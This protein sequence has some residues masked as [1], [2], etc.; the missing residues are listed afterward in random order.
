M[1]PI[2]DRP[3]IL[4]ILT[5]QQ[6]FDS[7][8]CYGNDWIETPNLDALASQSFVFENAYVTQPVC[9]PAR[10]SIMTGL[11]PHAIG[12]TRNN[13]PL[14]GDTKT[15]AEMISSDY[16]CAYFGKW[17]L[18]DDAIAQH[19]FEKWLSVDD[20]HRHR[21]SRKEHRFQEAD[22]KRFLRENKVEPPPPNVSYE[23]WFV[24][25][26][27]PE[28]LT[29]A[30]Y[31]GSEAS[32]FIREH[33]ASEHAD[34]PFMLYVSFFEPHPPYTGP[35][36]DLYD[37][38]KITVG[39]SFLQRPD[40]GS[41]LNR[42]RADYYMGGNLNPLGIEGGD[43]HDTTTEAGWRKLRAQYFANVTLVDRNVGRI[44]KALDDSGMADSTIVVLTSEH[45][46]MA[47]DHG[48]LEKRSLYEQASRVPLLMRV[49]WLG[50]H[51]T[52]IRGSF[53][54]IDLVPTLLDLVGQPA[55][56]HLQ[57]V[58][59]APVIRGEATLDDDVF[60]QWNGIGDR[61]LGSPAI[62]R[63]ISLPWRSVVSPDRWK[64]NLC[65]GDQCELYDLNSDPYEL[66]NLF[67]DPGQRDRIRHMA[68]SIRLW[69]HSTGDS[70]PLPAV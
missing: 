33:P 31:L 8:R 4:F 17:H 55:P 65:P 34:N 27:L 26:N 66:S 10:A 58:S 30:A 44:L 14:S 1:N 37:P 50:K 28:D 70:T 9:T 38:H 64:L 57:G 11:Y 67:N 36:N 54:Q 13:T 32:R 68:A 51:Q 7:M 39:P 52:R 19:G 22:Y 25:A 29:Q 18:G 3:N 6:R 46:E 20:S 61:N 62:N 48:M 43:F 35:L 40:S 2:P 60:I 16:L 47:G 24:G 69:Q 15:I 23:K 41:L 56:G 49:P 21:Y 42:L 59:R 63:M 5:D 12:L 53:G 45:G